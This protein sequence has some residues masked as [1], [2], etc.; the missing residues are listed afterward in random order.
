MDVVE[1]RGTDSVV[2]A[3]L[4]P[5]AGVLRRLAAVRKCISAVP[6]SR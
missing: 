5:D 6:S 2:G 4:R 3:A 1:G